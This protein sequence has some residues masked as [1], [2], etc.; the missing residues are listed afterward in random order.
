M[1]HRFARRLLKEHKAFQNSSLPGVEMLPESNITQYYVAM[2]VNNS[3]YTDQKFLL[4]I[5]IGNE[6]PVE[7]PSVQF[8]PQEN[9]V[10]PMHPH[11]YSNG[12]I[13]LNVLGKDW[14]PAC[15]VESV[16][17]SVQSMLSTNE[18]SERPPGDERYVR[19]APKDP[20]NVPFVYDD[21]TV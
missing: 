11:V 20:K 6:Y 1:S 12:H 16:V 3:L 4:S 21:D 2:T 18:V 8:L 9:Y 10:V 15:G 7:P 19:S 13:C 5:K 17:L 14:T